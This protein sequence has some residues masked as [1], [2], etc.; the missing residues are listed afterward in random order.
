MLHADIRDRTARWTRRRRRLWMGQMLN[1]FRVPGAIQSADV[2]DEELGRK[3]EV[4]VGVEY[5]RITV[6]DRD[7]YFD[8]VTGAFDSI[9]VDGPEASAPAVGAGEEASAPFAPERVAQS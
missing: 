1:E 3:I 9:G 5:V 7:Y 6:D 2:L 4:R 8:R